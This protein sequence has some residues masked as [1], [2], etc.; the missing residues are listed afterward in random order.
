MAQSDG[1]HEL[2]LTIINEGK[3][4]HLR[5]QRAEHALRDPSPGAQR[6]AAKA[7]LEFAYQGARQYERDFGDPEGKASCFTAQD[8]LGAAIEL[9][10]YYEQHVKESV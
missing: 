8:I 1:A 3:T 10:D 6:V 5:V 4:Y 7:W 9:A 2:A